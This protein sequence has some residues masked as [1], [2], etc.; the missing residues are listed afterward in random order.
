M[1][2]NTCVTITGQAGRLDD[3]LELLRKASEE[4]GLELDV[5]SPMVEHDEW[6]ISIFCLCV[7]RHSVLCMGGEVASRRCV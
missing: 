3:A 2:Y 6:A 5:V 7:H 1:S 4:G